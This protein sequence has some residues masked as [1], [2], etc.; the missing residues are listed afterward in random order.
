MTNNDTIP[1]KRTRGGYRPNAKRPTLYESGSMVRTT[2]SLPPHHMEILSAIDKET[3]P[4]IRVILDD[5]RIQEIIQTI[6]N[7]R[8]K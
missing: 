4:A 7:E 2:I 5:P 1:T 8:K 3:S 6:I